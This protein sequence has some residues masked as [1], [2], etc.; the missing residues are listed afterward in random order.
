MNFEEAEER[1]RYMISVLGKTW[2]MDLKDTHGWRCQVKNGPCTVTFSENSRD[3]Q[4][5][6]QVGPSFN[7]YS[8]SPAT[9]MCLAMAKVDSYIDRLEREREAIE[10]IFASI[11]EKR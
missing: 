10:K 8:T 4:A 11:G 7:A 3:Y 2:V 9:S 5:F 6:I 1:A